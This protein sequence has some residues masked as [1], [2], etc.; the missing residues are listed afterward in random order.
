VLTEAKV[1]KIK[2]WIPFDVADADLRNQLRNKMIRPTTIPQRL[3]DLHIEQAVAREALRL[4]FI[5]H[6]SL[7]RGLEGGAGRGGGLDVFREEKLT[8]QTLVKMM[9]LDM[10]VGSGGVL[11]HAPR[12]AQSA[13]MMMDAYEPEGVTL[14]TVDSIFMM[15]Q[16][17]VLSTVH[18]EAATQVFE[19]DCLVYLGTCISPVGTGKEGE[20][21]VTVTI[22]GKTE[23]VNVGQIKV[24]P[25]GF[26][27]GAG[28]EASAAVDASG[29]A[30]PPSN[31]PLRAEAAIQPAKGFDVGAGKGKPRTAAVT[32][33]VVGVIIDARGRP[34]NLPADDGTRI[35]KLVEWLDAMGISAGK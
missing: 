28:M 5:H 30:P 18:P 23:S 29:A 33:G 25:L 4:A 35:R 7:A 11:S 24:I 13:L 22:N 26:R 8:G 31:E 2:R 21:C 9:S 20:P 27:E 32:G 1:D 6:K 34:L 10:I 17:G 19:S 3:E 14:L 15:P 12:R 16:L